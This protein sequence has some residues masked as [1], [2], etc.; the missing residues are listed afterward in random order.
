[1]D[2]DMTDDTPDPAAMHAQAERTELMRIAAQRI[3]DNHE[4]GRRMA[5]A[6]TLQWA[7]DFVRFNPRR[8]EPLGTGEP[9]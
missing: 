4:H 6:D 8:V 1:M 9:A 5:E 7:Q 3:V 2:I